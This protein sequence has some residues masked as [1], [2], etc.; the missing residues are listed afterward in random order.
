MRA[1]WALHPLDRSV[2]ID[3]DT[4][5]GGLRRQTWHGHDV[6]CQDVDETRASRNACLLDRNAKAFRPP[7]TMRIVG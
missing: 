3:I 7:Q 6:A 2:G 5:C 1:D 4:E